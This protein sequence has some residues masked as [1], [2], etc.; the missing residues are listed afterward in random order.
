MRK[1]LFDRRQT[2]IPASNLPG[3]EETPPSPCP[4][5]RRER[6]AVSEPLTSSITTSRLRSG[7]VPDA[8][9]VRRIAFAAVVAGALDAIFSVITYVVVAGRYNLETV[10]QYIATGLLGHDAF[11]S[12]VAGIGTAAL[13]TAIHFALAAGFATAFALTAGRLLR[14]RAQAII[15]GIIYGAAVW[16]LMD[17]AVL[18]ALDVA[19]EPFGGG[20]WWPF[21]A[22]HAL[23]VGLPIALLTSSQ[24]STGR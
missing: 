14:T 17:A 21:L 9:L 10:L 1:I 4:A 6:P 13:G 20:Y 8:T 7:L 5:S 16:I 15:A 22:D 23:F 2:A 11:Q 12:G 18:P 24:I 19:H 3:H